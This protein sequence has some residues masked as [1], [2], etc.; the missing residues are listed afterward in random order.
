M[1]LECGHR[2]SRYYC[3]LNVPSGGM[4]GPS[5]MMRPI[6]AA[7]AE[8]AWAIEEDRLF[9]EMD[10][11]HDFNNPDPEESRLAQEAS[12]AGENA[13]ACR[14]WGKQDATPRTGSQS[15]PTGK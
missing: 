8:V 13:R 14:E 5:P 15:L 10:H 6:I 9:A 7:M 2:P 3:I 1:P 11:V 12:Y 4:G